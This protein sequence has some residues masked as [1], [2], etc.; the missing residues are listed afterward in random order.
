M[1]R[2]GNAEDAGL[3]QTHR[4]IEWFRLG[5]TLKIMKLQTPCH[6]QSFQSLDQAAVS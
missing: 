5:D 4:I 3:V 2:L 6:R 1:G